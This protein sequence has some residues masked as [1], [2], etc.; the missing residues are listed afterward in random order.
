MRQIKRSQV[1][2]SIITECALPGKGAKI[3]SNTS[4]CW[5]KNKPNH[6]RS[7]PSPAIRK[8]CTTQQYT[9]LCH[10]KFTDTLSAQ[11]PATCIHKGRCL[12][13]DRFLSVDMIRSTFP[14]ETKAL[15]GYADLSIPSSSSNR[16]HLSNHR[17]AMANPTRHLRSRPG[18]P[19]S[20]SRIAAETWLI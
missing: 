7:E 11:V 5:S 1:N 17:W 18:V 12:L 2:P 15:H 4:F 8:T 13:I 9:E 6:V 14:G 19:P 10:Q 16:W 3:E 20:D